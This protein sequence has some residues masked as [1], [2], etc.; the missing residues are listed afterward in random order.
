M[1]VTEDVRKGFGG[2]IAVNNISI[3]VNEGEILGIIGP[4]GAG[5]TTLLNCIAGYYRPEK[6]NIIFNGK[7]IVGLPPHQICHLGIARTFQIV[8]SFPGMTALEN[9]KVAAVFGGRNSKN[10]E[11]RAEELMRFVDFPADKNVPVG[12]LNNMQLKRL[13]LA[14]AL[15]TDCRL[16]LL[17]EVAAGLTLTEIPDF[18]DLIKRIR[19]SGITVI[20]IEH[21]MEF[22]KG[23][24]DRIMVM[25]FGTQIAEGTFEDIKDN[26]D[27]TEAYLGVDCN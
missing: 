17:D 16:L 6:G 3:E 4:N 27:V 2:L 24:C 23:V 5:K 19:D 12:N 21:V 7:N 20:T 14:R 26:A 11:K 9:V 22:I 10:P 25:Q 8:R 1:L 15:A 18:I 13:E